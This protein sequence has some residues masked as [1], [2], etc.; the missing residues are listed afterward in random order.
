M[1]TEQLNELIV[2]SLEHEMGGVKVYEA[3][4][5]CALNDDLRKE[6]TKYLDQ[7]KTHV[8]RLQEVCSAFGLDPQKETPGRKVV[9]H[10]GAGLVQAMKMAL[11]AGDKDAA[12]LVACECV[13]VAETKDHLDWEL[14]AQC[15]PKLTGAQAAA[16]KDASDQVEDE[17]DVHLYHT[18]GWCRELW[19]KSLGL[20]VVLPPPEERKNVKTAIGAA[21]AE[22]A[23][24][25]HR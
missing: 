3:A 20:K 18:K 9:R 12:E 22:Q 8:R 19:L 6:W 1:K 21:R 25:P 13:V 15:A 24:H 10:L 11:Q 2:Q 4:L 5:A 7:T 23:A 16:L 14:L 17:E